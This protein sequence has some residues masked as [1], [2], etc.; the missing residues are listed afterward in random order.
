M[1]ALAVVIALGTIAR[2]EPDLAQFTDRDDAGWRTQASRDG[3]TL[4]R[5]SVPGSSYHE[6]RAVV[7]LAVDPAVAADE[8]WSAIRGGDME[9]LKRREILREGPDSLVIYDQ[10]RTPVVSDRDYTITVQRLFDP[11]RRR[12]QFRCATA[13]QLGPPVQRGLV[14]IPVIRA[15]WMT[16]PDGSGGTRLTYFAFSEP[17]GLVAAFLVRPAQA[18]RSLADVLRMRARLLR[19]R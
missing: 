13:N 1:R 4:E 2:A 18:S 11:A 10:I 17:G 5:R 3:V 14:R 8:I 19:R 7:S 15:G 9:A 12:T 16:E 6:Y